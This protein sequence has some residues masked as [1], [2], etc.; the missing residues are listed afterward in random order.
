MFKKLR[1]LTLGGLVF[2][3]TLTLPE[4]PADAFPAGY[5]YLLFPDPA[6]P[7]LYLGI[8]SPNG[9]S[10]LTLTPAKTYILTQQ[11]SALLTTNTQ[12]IKLRNRQTRQ[13]MQDWN[14]RVL[15]GSCGSVNARWK[16]FH[17]GSR[18]AFQGANG[19]CTHAVVNVGGIGWPDTFELSQCVERPQKW[20]STAPAR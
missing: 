11:W 3:L 6:R 1:L 4:T 2:A 12:I 8:D 17:A 18:S 13:C 5:Q 20:W 14:G 10:Q 16:Q 7:G 19:G 15:T 9:S